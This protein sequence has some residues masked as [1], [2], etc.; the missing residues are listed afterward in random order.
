M[1]LFLNLATILN[2]IFITFVLFFE[3]KEDSR[4][5][6]WVL[7]LYF[8]PLVGVIL[9]ILLSGHFFTKTKQLTRISH[10]FDGLNVLFYQEYKESLQDFYSSLNTPVVE[11]NKSLVKMNV[12]GNKSPLVTTV[13][14]RIYCWGQDMFPEMLADMEAAT[15]SIYIESFIIHDDTTGNALMDVLCKKAQE[16]IEVKLLYDD[17]GSILTPNSFF[18]RL[19]KAGGQVQ[20]FFPVKWRLPLSINFRNHRKITVIDGTIG[21]MGGINIGD[22]Y[23]NCNKSRD[24]LLWRDTHIRLTGP[25]VMNLHST[26]LIDWFTT[27]AWHTRLKKTDDITKLFSPETIE[28]LQ[29]QLSAA[30]HGIT[31][32]H[33]SHK[34]IPTQI[35]TAGPDDL[36]TTEIE[37]ALIRMIMAAKRYVYI[38]TPYFTP[39][40]E[41]YKALKLAAMSGVDVRIMVPDQW[42]KFYVREAAYQFIREML[43]FGIKFYHYNGF[44]HSK[45]LVADDK[46]STIG[47]TN[48]D[49]RSFDL[50]FEVN[51]IFYDENLACQCRQIFENDIENS[52]LATSQWFESM[53]L[54]RRALWAFFKMFSPLM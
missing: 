4:R 15:Q 12:T 53:P 48:I 44:I 49:T 54:L 46:I 45:T 9:Y 11:E 26:F 19:T 25:V 8:L 22:E 13:T 5:W 41:F 47:S 35:I 3:R 17:V 30:K 39:T 43:D 6:A 29:Q 37:D 27:P 50:H 7:V 34:G 52:R 18:H 38:Q 28:L 31:E 20:A 24:K 2:I 36:C 14:S 1:E 16:G 23:A 42:D 10:F 51:A 40:Q 21:Y 33:P 32:K